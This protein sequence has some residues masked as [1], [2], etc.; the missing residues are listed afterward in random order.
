MYKPEQILS[1]L[2]AGITATKP[3]VPMLGDKWLVSSCMQKA[4]RRGDTKRALSA[5]TSLWQQDRQNFWTRLHTV[6][7]ED[8]SANSS[9]VVAVFTATAHS[10][11]RRRVGDLKAGLF[12]TRLLCESVKCRAGDELILLVERSSELK[13]L[14]EQFSQA[15]DAWLIDCILDEEAPLAERALAVWYLA[16]TKKFPSDIMPQRNGDPEAA[17]KA[18]R[19]LNAPD[20]LV[21]S[22]IAVMGRTG[23]PLSVFQPLLWQTFQQQ[24]KQLRIAHDTIKSCPDVGGVPLFGCDIFTRIG[25]SCFRQMQRAVPELKPFSVKQI[26][27]GVFYGE[28][29]LL[30]RFITS[31]FLAELRQAGEKADV[32][33]AGLCL[34]SYADLRKCLDANEQ[35]LANIR[36]EL[37]QQYLS[38]SALSGVR[39]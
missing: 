9:T 37:L 13:K 25:Q 29:G 30:N 17:K 31:P 8:V 16:G 18:L 14:R 24:G 23:W 2:E 3:P 22:S 39:A 5:A 10:A 1:Q 12:L 27:T 38:G 28:G 26:G 34:F 15:N 7:G 19:S 21:E 32:E 33:H 4:I 35:V 20:D 11:W 36:T 6:S